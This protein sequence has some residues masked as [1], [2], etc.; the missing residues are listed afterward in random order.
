MVCNRAL[1]AFYLVLLLSLIVPET[2][3]ADLG[4]GSRTVSSV[5]S[6]LWGWVS[7]WLPQDESVATT[8]PAGPEVGPTVPLCDPKTN[9]DGCKGDLGS[10]M[11]PNG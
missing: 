11:D 5:V 2:F 9:P 4:T 10:E 7:S 6:T 3:A 8:D 1:R